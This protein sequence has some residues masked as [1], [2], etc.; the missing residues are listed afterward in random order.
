MRTLTFTQ[1][2]YAKQAALLFF[3]VSLL[4]LMFSI[5]QPSPA[6][7]G[8]SENARG[9][10]WGG[11]VLSNPA[12]YEGIGWI[13]MNNLSDG[14]AINYGVNIPA[15]NGLLSGYAWSEWYGW[16]SFNSVDLAGCVPMP[17]APQRIGNSITGG[18]RIIAI[19]D[20]GA[21]RGG[22][23]GCVS[24]SGFGYGLTVNTATNPAT[25]DGHASAGAD[26]GWIDFSGV[27]LGTPSLSPDLQILARPV[28]RPASGISVGQRVSLTSSVT[29]TGSGPAG[30]FP[31]IFRVSTSTMSL[32]SGSNISNLAA[33]NSANTTALFTPKF[34][35]THT[36]SACADNRIPMTD[37]GDIT[38]SREDNNCSFNATFTAI[39]CT[40]SLSASPSTIDQGESA[41]LSWSPSSSYCGFTTCTFT[42]GPSYSGASGTRTVSPL[43][44]ST[45]GISCVGP[46]GTTPV[47]L[48]TVTVRTPI[49]SIEATPD[50][51]RSGNPVDVVWNA[52]EVSLC[53]ITRN[54]V[55][56]K[57]PLPGGAS[58]SVSG[59]ERD[60]ITGQ[61]T[62]AISCRNSASP[63][64]TTVTKTVNVLSSFEEF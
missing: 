21:N 14:T 61:T 18:A 3:C 16:I 28:V 34:P 25:L 1:T 63:D 57:G 58:N 42:D 23:N 5:L 11:G 60:T 15:S 26:L 59:S 41:T 64:L 45:Y 20:A 13:S 39:A 56:W 49:I 32:V 12:G 2:A 48:A 51:V 38:E 17:T 19:R 7:A 30:T 22:Y 47:A 50:R 37:A 29:N 62:Y 33:G 40:T 55:A 53:N 52:T 43:V 4:I 10:A 31:N 24:L 8:A 46:Y 6:L 36:V 9:F 44:T 54:G 27:T 35:G